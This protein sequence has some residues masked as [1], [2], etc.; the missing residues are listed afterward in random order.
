[1]ITLP[2]HILVVKGFNNSY[3]VPMCAFG[4]ESFNRYAHHVVKYHK[5]DP[6]F[7][8][9]CEV[10]NCSFTTT[11]WTSFKCHMSRKHQIAQ[12]DDGIDNPDQRV[13]VDHDDENYENEG[14]PPN[15]SDGQL[16]AYLLKLGVKHKLSDAGIATVMENTESIVHREL[17]MLRKGI[18]EILQ[19][20]GID[21]ECVTSIDFSPSLNQFNTKYKCEMFYKTQCVMVSPQEVILG[22]S[23][24]RKS[25]RKLVHTGLWQG[26]LH[27]LQWPLLLT[28]F[29]FN[30][31]MDK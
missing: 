6:H 13:Q 30:P 23:F 2:L 21:T 17:N 10:F 16:S 1:M 24:V 20:E 31:S 15:R 18:E 25:W 28:W 8:V 12:N 7:S 3:G 9:I 4:T 26:L 14:L 29:N 5:N 27:S 19:K 22:S 11:S